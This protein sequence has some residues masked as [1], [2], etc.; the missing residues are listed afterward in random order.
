M[1]LIQQ[2]SLNVDRL[3]AV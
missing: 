1:A 2:S 3:W